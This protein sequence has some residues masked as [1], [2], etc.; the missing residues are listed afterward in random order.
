[1]LL[2]NWMLYEIYCNE[3]LIQLYKVFRFFQEKFNTTLTDDSIQYPELKIS[4][5]IIIQCLSSNKMLLI[6]INIY[7]YDFKKSSFA[8]KSY[9]VYIVI[10]SFTINNVPWESL[11]GLYLRLIF[12]FGISYSYIP[13]YLFKQRRSYAILNLL[14]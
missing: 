1:M 5:K 3:I 14:P 6:D 11:V 7:Y 4:S 13:I 12:S 10:S 9:K 8:L 2:H